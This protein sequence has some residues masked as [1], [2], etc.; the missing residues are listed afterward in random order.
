MCYLMLF[1]YY[2][3]QI[4]FAHGRII[5]CTLLVVYY[6]ILYCTIELFFQEGFFRL[7]RETSLKNL[8]FGGDPRVTVCCVTS[9][10]WCCTFWIAFYFDVYPSPFRDIRLLRS[11]SKKQKSREEKEAGFLMFFV[12]GHGLSDLFFWA[13]G[14]GSHAKVFE[15]SRRSMAMLLPGRKMC[16][17]HSNK[18]PNRGPTPYL[19]PDGQLP[20]FAG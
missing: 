8:S 17:G 13:C 7:N 1:T 10:V 20:L 9:D 11:C 19:A 4:V 18:H 12:I 6:R 15:D 3:F 5:C 2:F 14:R 16:D